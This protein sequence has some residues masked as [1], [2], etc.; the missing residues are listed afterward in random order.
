MQEEQDPISKMRAVTISREYGSGGG[1]IALRLAKRLGWQLIDHEIVVQ[2]ARDLGIS[3]AEA[4]VQDERVESIISR[5]ISSM[6]AVNPA[7]FAATPTPL[8]ADTQV[9]HQAL[10][11]VVEGAVAI[12]NVVIVGRGGQVLL[13]QRRD[14]LHIRI[15]APLEKRITYVMQREDLDRAKARSR[16][17]SKDHDR[18]RYLQETYQERPGNSVLYDLTIN[19]SVIDLDSTVDI[20]HLALERKAIQLSTPTQKLGPGAGLARY[21]GQPGDFRPPENITQSQT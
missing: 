16:I 3:V 20:I 4:E 7:V 15:V 21:P 11:K 10:T 17:Q 19:T 2:V 13:G 18:V 12:G 1:E 6:Q 9:Y 14:V 5:M 8:V